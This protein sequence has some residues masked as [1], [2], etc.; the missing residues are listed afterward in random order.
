MH[1]IPERDPMRGPHALEGGLGHGPR[2]CEQQSQRGSNVPG[3]NSFP[4]ETES[5]RLKQCPDQKYS[6]GEDGDPPS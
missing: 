6:S 3:P 5:R 2:Y 4:G 1:A